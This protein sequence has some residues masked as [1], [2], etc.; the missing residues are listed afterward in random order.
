ML[1]NRV[2]ITQANRRTAVFVRDYVLGAVFGILV[3]AIVVSFVEVM[4]P[5]VS[6]YF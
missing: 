1:G 6:R 5:L 3:V 4:W 2:A